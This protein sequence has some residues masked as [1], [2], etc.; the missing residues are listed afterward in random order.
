MA[1]TTTTTRGEEA[2]AA[3]AKLARSLLLAIG[4][5]E[6]V[7]A[8]GAE[9]A[10]S[11]QPFLD[12]IVASLVDDGVV[13]LARLPDRR[14][15]EL[16]L[17]PAVLGPAFLAALDRRRGRL[18]G[19]GERARLGRLYAIAGDPERA[20]SCYREVLDE[21]TFLPL[22][23]VV[24]L[25]EA[26]WRAGKRAVALG[27]VDRIAEVVLTGDAGKEGRPEDVALAGGA[28]ERARDVALA[29][30]AA[31]VREGGRD[32]GHAAARAVALGR[33]AVLLYERS[34]L[35]N[36]AARALDGLGRAQ[37]ATGDRNAARTTFER[38]RGLAIARGDTAAAA[39]SLEISADAFLSTGDAEA[40]VDR[41]EQASDVHA[42]AGDRKAAARAAL[43]AAELRVSR[44][45]LA[46]AATTLERARGHAAAS[47]DAALEATTR[48]QVARAAVLEGQL[49]VAL[50]EAEAALLDQER[51]ADE[52][53]AAEARVVRASAL[54]ATGARDE[55][56]AELVQARD[57]VAG[58][59]AAGALELRAEIALG[60]GRLDETHAL[61]ADA[62]RF[63]ALESR[64]VA[65]LRTRVRR[66]EI[67][68]EKG[69]SAAATTLIAAVATCEAPELVA[70]IALV[71]AAL[72]QDEGPR[73][74]A[75][76]RAF[77][78]AFATDHHGPR[79]AS[80]TARARARLALKKPAVAAADA[81]AALEAVRDARKSLAEERRAA[82]MATAPAREACTTARAV[83]DALEDYRARRKAGAAAKQD[84]ETA[85]VETALNA[86]DLLLGQLG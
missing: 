1:E 67:A 77:D 72:A 27:A 19:P 23:L 15:T 52:R 81:R 6:E 3:R 36:E 46:T 86:L 65:A 10:A 39:R 31:T 53:G 20:A 64:P 16:D 43:R 37:I 24:E 49:G 75:L 57:A 18:A 14:A 8:A 30:E 40:A 21:K 32:A 25:A 12:D 62:G 41:L 33:A 66:A 79:V 42:S 17:D 2:T 84:D 34:G 73:R 68:L 47:G 74:A 38:R 56:T 78:L 54:L 60:E 35:K 58:E 82:Y 11:D 80:A 50:R 13:S 61:L 44:G 26:A 4:A 76:D 29:L 69:D 7:A 9:E 48:I 5:T 45:D 28:L 63:H 55:A 70:R 83:R 22:P 71:E 85:G 59:A 51:L